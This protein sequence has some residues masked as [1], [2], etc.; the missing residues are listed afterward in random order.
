M[1]MQ[2]RKVI[3]IGGGES[4]DRKSRILY[5]SVEVELAVVAFDFFGAPGVDVVGNFEDLLVDFG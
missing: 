3:R 2:C 5:L 4:Y 1:V